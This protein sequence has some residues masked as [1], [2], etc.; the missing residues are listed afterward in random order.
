MDVPEYET[1]KLF[2]KIIFEID[3]QI[4][5]ISGDICFLELRAA[6]HE[7]NQIVSCLSYNIVHEYFPIN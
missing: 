2:M 4:I 6:V 3:C 5:A 7:Y 1:E